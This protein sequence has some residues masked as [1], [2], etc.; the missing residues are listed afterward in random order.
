MVALEEK[1]DCHQSQTHPLRTMNICT[2]FHGSP[3]NSSSGG[4]TNLLADRQ[5][6][7]C[8]EIL[9]EQRLYKLLE[10]I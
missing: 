7:K 5:R 2:K 9:L 1:S 10:Q 3:F 6:E 4:P 8:A